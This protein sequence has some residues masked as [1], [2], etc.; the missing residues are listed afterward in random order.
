[1]ERIGASQS[2][3]V[4]AA[5]ANGSTRSSQLKKLV[6]SSVD[7]MRSQDDLD[8]EEIG[9]CDL[10]EM[11]LDERVSR[12]LPIALRRRPESV[13]LQDAFYSVS[14]DLVAEMTQSVA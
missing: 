11:R 9:S 10:T 13:I 4:A 12:G 1:M 2:L 7:D 6:V 14:A 8:G 5:R 3:V